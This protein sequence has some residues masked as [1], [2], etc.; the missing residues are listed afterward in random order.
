MGQASSFFF[1]QQY[2][3]FV[4]YRE[5][6]VFGSMLRQE[7]MLDFW[8]RIQPQVI[9]VDEQ[10]AARDAELGQYMA[11]RGF[12]HVMPNLWF[13]NDLEVGQEPYRPS[14]QP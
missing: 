6:T 13:A 3:E 11:E 5:G 1:L 9:L 4:E 2:K 7:S 10:D 8:R 12:V 14:A